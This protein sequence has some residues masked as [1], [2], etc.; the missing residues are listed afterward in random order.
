[1]NA[2]K[3]IAKIANCPPADLDPMTP[4]AEVAGL[5]SLKLVRLVLGIES[6]IN[7]QLSEA[8]LEG[9]Y[10]VRDVDRLLQC[11]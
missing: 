10:S 3:L 4:L 7:R 1:M 11:V 8:E 5:D 2:S 9:L 6:T